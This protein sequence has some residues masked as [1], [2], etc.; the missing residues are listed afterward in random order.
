[1]PGA[2]AQSWSSRLGVGGS[3]TLLTGLSLLLFLIIHSEECKE[4]SKRKVTWSTDPAQTVAITIGE[5]GVSSAEPITV[6]QMFH[7]A[8][9][10]FP[11]HPAL[12]F[13]EGD[14][15]EKLSYMDYYNL[16]IRAAKSFLKV[17]MF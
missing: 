4:S 8:K 17:V 15:W 16:C 12:C 1:M 9:E 14:T 2:G 3:C 6:G 11:N 10:Q 7:Q 13:K 5:D